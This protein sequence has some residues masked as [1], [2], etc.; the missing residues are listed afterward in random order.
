MED[1]V[2]LGI[3]AQPSPGRP[4]TP[5]PRIAAPRGYAEVGGGW[6]RGIRCG[7]EHDL[8]VAPGR[9]GA[10]ENLPG[11]RVVAGEISPGTE[12]AAPDAHDHDVTHHDRR[13]VHG[14]ALL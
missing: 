11:V 12:L 9:I 8:R 10:P 1:Q 7:V 13:R 3:P 2:E 4:A 14:D 5:A 6:P